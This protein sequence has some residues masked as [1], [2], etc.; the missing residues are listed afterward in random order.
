MRR[1]IPLL[2]LVV[3]AGVFAAQPEKEPGDFRSEFAGSQACAECHRRETKAWRDSPHAKHATPRATP[4]GGADGA[5]GSR[6]MQAYYRRDKQGFLRIVPECFDLR[7]K[8]FKHVD[9]V[10]DAIRGTMAGLPHPPAAPLEER[11]FDR[12]CAGCHAS[13]AHTTLDAGTGRMNTRWVSPAIDCESC[14]GPGAAHAEAWRNLKSDRPLA[15]LEKLDPRAATAICARCHGGPPTQGDFG[16]AD[17]EHFIGLLIDREG[18]FPNGVA[19]GQIYQHPGFVRSPCYR[20]GGLTCVDCHDS[21]GPGLRNAVLEDALC[22]RCHQGYAARSH[23]HH[24]PRRNGARCIECH[25]PRLLKGLVAHQRDH[26]ISSPLPASPYVPDACTAC[27]KEKNKTWSA[28]RYRAWWGEPPRETLDAIEAI[29]RARRK[30]PR[31]RRLL[32]RALHHPDPYFRANAAR[33]LK[34]AA[35]ILKD[36]VPEVRFVAVQIARQNEDGE[37]ALVT[38]SRDQEP[39]IRALADL[40][41]IARRQ[42]AREEMRADL[43]TAV[44]HHRDLPRARL[45]LGVMDVTQGKPLHAIHEFEEALAFVPD[46]DEAWFGLATAYTALGREAAAR[47]AQLERAKI[48]ERRWRA[49]PWDMTLVSATAGSY[50]QAGDHER[51]RRILEQALGHVSAGGPTAQVRAM[52]AKLDETFGRDEAR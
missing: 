13:Q 51:A 52:L 40:A 10:L 21:H 16:P 38:L 43:A 42:P 44:R 14:H 32:R 5:V 31:A 30:D 8:T 24:D 3:L 9:L 17:A 2:L 50:I 35:P 15:R 36:P 7:D 28:E 33:Y 1:V 45:V 6:W 19:S 23:H 20:E 48:L 49:R 12:D 18:M 11:S 4:K 37:E 39:V 34:E 27:H 26:T 41:L 29:Y 25:M 22:T 46:M 47:K